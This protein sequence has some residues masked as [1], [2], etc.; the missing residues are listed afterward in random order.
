M[1]NIDEIA[2]KNYRRMNRLHRSVLQKTLDQF[3]LYLGQHRILF[4]LMKQEE[5]T[6]KQI[7]DKLDMKKETLSVSL[8]RM[9]KSG[10][11]I[12]KND[13]QDHRIKKITLTQQGLET[14][15]LCYGL[16]QE[17]DQ[18]MFTDFSQEE[19]ERVSLLFA[20]MCQNLEAFK[21]KDNEVP[22]GS[23]K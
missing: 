16:I 15:K 19:V 23:N 12:R 9:E 1:E 7:A 14:A 13:K 2:I 11:L 10:L 20:Q 22:E 3:G 5:M 4:Q 21:N 6:Q 17:A 18:A 8:T